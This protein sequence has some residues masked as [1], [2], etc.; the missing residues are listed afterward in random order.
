M[1]C[2]CGERGGETGLAQD[3]RVEAAGDAPQVVDRFP[4][5]GLREVQVVLGGRCSRPEQP[6]RQR[7]ADESLLRAVVQISLEPPPLLVTCG[8]DSTSRGAKVGEL[9]QCFGAQTFVLER[10]VY[11]RYQVTDGLR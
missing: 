2:E 5:F 10:E 3:D 6:H 11:G 7:E 8:E 1:F 9:C 4:D